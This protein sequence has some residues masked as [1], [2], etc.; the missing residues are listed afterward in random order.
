MD[1]KTIIV[2]TIVSVAVLV[3]AWLSPGL[4]R[5][6]D[7]HDLNRYKDATSRKEISRSTKRKPSNIVKGGGYYPAGI[8]P[9]KKWNVIGRRLFFTG[10]Q[11]TFSK[12]GFRFTMPGYAITRKYSDITA[13]SITPTGYLHLRLSGFEDIYIRSFYTA[14]IMKILA[15]KGIRQIPRWK[16]AYAILSPHIL[17]IVPTSMLLMYLHF[18]NND[19]VLGVLWGLMPYINVS[20]T[21]F[22]QLEDAQS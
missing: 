20:M 19:W 11:I 15:R 17:F 4:R 2:L 14:A 3:F 1:S 22:N 18:R 6:W 12:N 21:M 9:A 13:A 8:Q 10:A 5:R 16:L 7:K